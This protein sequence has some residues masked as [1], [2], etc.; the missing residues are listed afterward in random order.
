[1]PTEKSFN[2]WEGVY[3]SFDD[4]PAAGPG[5]DGDIWLERSLRVARQSIDDIGAGRR[6]SHPLIQRN[7]LM[8]ATAAAK[9]K[10]VSILDFGGGPGFGFLALSEAHP[11]V[12]KQCE[13]QIVENAAV[14]RA[15]STL[16]ADGVPSFHS[17][18]PKKRE[19]DIVFSASALQYVADWRGIIATL[20]AYGAPT[21][22]LSDI[23]AGNFP[24][25]VTL[26]NYYDSRIPHWF[27][28]ID[29]LI[30]EV[31]THGYR[32]SKMSHYDLEILGERGPPPM[33]NF[34]ENL[35]VPY[36]LHLLFTK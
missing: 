30:A 33:G 7:E 28:N 3:R 35:R 24:A 29:E 12:A 36:A 16:F 26:Q 34:P 13:Y 2:V 18:F 21:L 32:I 19:F 1:M 17:Q 9:Q 14:C 15:C 22:I 25:F 27:L 4:A 23:Y 11:E 20:A 31:G 8:V 10:P 5:F 6:I